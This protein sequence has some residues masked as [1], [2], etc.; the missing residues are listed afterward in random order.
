MMKVPRDVI[1]FECIPTLPREVF[2]IWQGN[3]N[4][5]PHSHLV[6]I[7]LYCVTIKTVV[8]LNYRLRNYGSW[9]TDCTNTCTSSH[10]AVGMQTIS[11]PH[12]P[13]AH[14]GT[15]MSSTLIPSVLTPRSRFCFMKGGGKAKLHERSFA[16]ADF[17]FCQP[18]LP[19]LL[20]EKKHKS[21]NKNSQV[22]QCL[23]LF[24]STRI[25][26]ESLGNCFLLHACNQCLKICLLYVDIQDIG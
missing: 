20:D 18:G 21:V 17:H 23:V 25:I 14:G 7:G 9:A 26:L 6:K 3:G 16:C 4:K 11:D 1:W 12:S 13:L 15:T 8:A 2:C 24:L 22:I 5:Q 10:Y 19:W